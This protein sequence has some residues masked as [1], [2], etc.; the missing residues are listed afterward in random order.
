MAERAADR[1]RA[2]ML[3][4]AVLLLLRAVVAIF[5]QSRRA[6]DRTLARRVES[7][8]ELVQSIEVE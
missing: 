7:L 2:R 4:G 5:A 8:L 3:R 6:D 1:R